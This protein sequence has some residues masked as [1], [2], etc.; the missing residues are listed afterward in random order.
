MNVMARALSRRAR[1]ARETEAPL[2]QDA[3]QLLSAADAARDNRQWLEA[4]GLYRQYLDRRTDDAPIWVQLGHALKESGNLG[5]A[6]T[7]YKQSL[8]LAPDVADTQLQLGHLY[9]KMRNLS[10]A[11]AAYREALKIDNGLLD[12]RRELTALGIS[13]YGNSSGAEISAPRTPATFIDLSDAFFYLRHH[14]TVSGIQRVQLGVANAIIAMPFEQRAGI[15]FLIDTED[16]SGYVVIDDVFL[17]EIEGELARDQVE[18][19]R[20]IEIMRSATSLGRKY[21]PLAGDTLLILGAFWVSDN[22]EER[23][24]E[25]C[26][27]GVRVGTLIHDIIPLTHPEFCVK[28]LTNSFKDS[29]STVL[30]VASFILTV[31]EYTGR[32][33]REFVVQNNLPQ[34]PIYMLKSAHKTWKLPPASDLLSSAVRRVLG[35]DYILYVSTIE[36]RKNHAYLFRIWKRLIDERAGKVPKLVLV[37][38]PGWRV[39]DL[40]EQLKSTSNLNGQIVI[41][42]DLS[43]AELAALYRSALFTVFPSLE[44]GWGLPIGESLIFGRPCVASNSSS[45]PE[46]AG[47]FVDYVDPFNVNDGYEKIR[48]FIEDRQSLERRADF[49][50]RN[51]RPREWSDVANDMMGIIE[52]VTRDL[53]TPIRQLAPP[54]MVPCRIYH[55]GHQD[56]ISRFIEFGRVDIHPF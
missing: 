39:N 19:A 50:Q 48:G 1:D 24:I 17:I 28:S 22:I 12:A 27:D 43:D 34:T 47:E 16:R 37:G 29:F 4:A 52:S 14:K 31:S 49:I 10:D 13:V 20:L 5:D 8:E 23:V 38:R 9:K 54:L 44:E 18:H 6:E 55:L 56:D 3:G 45:V 53:S 40:M 26:R 21:E 11:I 7:A 42:H 25:L 33:L 35:Q 51:F 41:L 30:R 46:V 15:F 2:A 32:C 36:V